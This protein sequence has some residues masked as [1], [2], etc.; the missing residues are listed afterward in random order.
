[1]QRWKHRD[2]KELVQGHDEN[3]R[4]RSWNLKSVFANTPLSEK[5]GGV[6][7]PGSRKKAQASG[8]EINQRKTGWK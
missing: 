3:T 8:Y 6:V 5:N 7:P 2:I 4:T 1:M